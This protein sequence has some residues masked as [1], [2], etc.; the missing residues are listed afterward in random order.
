MSKLRTSSRGSLLSN[1]SGR[2]SRVTS[3]KKLITR[4]YDKENPVIKC[5]PMSALRNPS[6]GLLNPPSM[7]DVDIVDD[8]L[9]SIEESVKV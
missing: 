1:K 2:N 8:D 6:K 3:T 9:A 4:K 7:V 5:A